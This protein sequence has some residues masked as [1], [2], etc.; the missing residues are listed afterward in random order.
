[1][2]ESKISQQIQLG[3]LIQESVL[4]QTSL[5]SEATNQRNHDATIFIIEFQTF[6]NFL[7]LVFSFTSLFGFNLCPE[8]QSSEN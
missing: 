7:C 2:H 8:T 1:M 3:L 6:W 5:S 4:Y